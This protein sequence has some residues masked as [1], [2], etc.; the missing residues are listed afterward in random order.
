LHKEKWK[1]VG[2]FKFEYVNVLPD[3]NIKLDR[4][5]FFEKTYGEYIKACLWGD[6]W[7]VPVSKFL[8]KVIND[9]YKNLIVSYKDE[10]TLT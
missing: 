5:R 4:P 1:K 2:E 6:F 3:N 7:A 8:V 10:Y 9:K